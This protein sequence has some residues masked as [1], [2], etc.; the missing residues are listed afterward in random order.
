MELT[1][2]F[3]EKKE[4][5]EIHG[6]KEGLKLLIKRLN[7]LVNHEPGSYIAYE[8][9]EGNKHHRDNRLA[10]HYVIYMNNRKPAL[11]A[12]EMGS[13]IPSTITRPEYEN[14]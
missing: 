7:S 13:M 5:V 14:T 3:N 10:A 1:F 8:C 9:T 6:D 12:K 4:S 11:G 2:E